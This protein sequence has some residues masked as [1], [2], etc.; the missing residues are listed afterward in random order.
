MPDH[1]LGG[2]YMTDIEILLPQ[3]YPFLFVDELISAD[4][5]EIIGTKIYDTSFLFFLEHLPNQKI[6]PNTI[7]IESI[8][9]CGGAGINQIDLFEKF[10]WGLASIE[11]AHFFGIVEANTLV[12][13]IVQNLKVSNKIIKQSGTA[14]CK[15][16]KI[17]E[18]TW[19]CLRL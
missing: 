16:K 1:D 4:R 9:Q 15:E 7:L 14:F 3:R 12:K 10:L 5:N 13:M 8:V 11:S 6:I 19:M 17:L 2:M 18:A